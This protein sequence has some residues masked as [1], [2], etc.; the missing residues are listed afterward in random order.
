MSIPVILVV[1]LCIC[2]VVSHV[3]GAIIDIMGMLK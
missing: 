3:K 2:I 1:T